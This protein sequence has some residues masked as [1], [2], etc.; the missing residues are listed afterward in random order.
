M[1]KRFIDPEFEEICVNFWQYAKAHRY[2]GPRLPPSF[3]KVL[4]EGS[5]DKP[6]NYPLNI[7]FPA[8][9]IIIDSLDIKDQIA[10]YAVYICS[11]YRQGKKVPIKVIANEIG[12]NRANFYKKADKVAQQSWKQAKNLT[13][14]HSK[15][16]NAS[17]RTLQKTEEVID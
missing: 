15:L 5:P 10:F 6:I 1:S 14:L 9:A 17:A 3:A 13:M 11:A 8:L 16:D 12:I 4:N 2:D 7:Y